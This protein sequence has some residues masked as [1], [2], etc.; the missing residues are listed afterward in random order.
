MTR[1]I[2]VVDDNLTIRQGLTEILGSM[3]VAIFTAANGQEGLEILRQQRQN[4]ELVLLDMDMPVM[5]G[6]QTY[7]KLQQVAPEVKVIVLTSLTKAEV[8]ARLGYR[9]TPSYLRKPFEIDR[10]LHMVRTE[11]GNSLSPGAIS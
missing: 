9:E 5:N 3:A 8:Q 6:E 2:L 4:I 1:A 10:L 7:K 11:F